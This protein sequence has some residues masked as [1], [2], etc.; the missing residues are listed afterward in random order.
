METCKTCR[1]WQQRRRDDVGSIYGSGDHQC[2]CPKIVSPGDGLPDADGAE[3]CDASGYFAAILPGPDF[4]CVH[5]E[6]AT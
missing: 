1:W 2:V 5:H 4:G 6:R 3:L